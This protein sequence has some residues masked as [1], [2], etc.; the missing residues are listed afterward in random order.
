MRTKTYI[1]GLKNSQRI[2]VLLDDFGVYT[3]VGEC[4]HLF[5]NHSHVLATAS[6]L[7]ALSYQNQRAIAAGET[8]SAGIVVT[9]YM[10]NMVS[11]NVQIDLL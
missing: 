8:V 2:R 10:A 11:I 3:T 5:T 1:D 9:H 7:N 6:G 4:R